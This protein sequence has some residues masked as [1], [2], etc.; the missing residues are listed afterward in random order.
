MPVSRAEVIEAVARASGREVA[1]VH[2]KLKRGLGSLASI[3]ATA[4]FV[5]ILGTVRGFSDAL[6]RLDDAKV[7]T[8]VIADGVAAAL[9]VVAL[10]LLVGILASWFYTHLQNQIETL[11]T[12]MQDASL[13]LLN[14]LVLYRP[15]PDPR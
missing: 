8:G 13:D 1:R 11:E 14:R 3:A 5:G 4:P 6:R 10:G 15:A 7:I 12:E 9:L 2:L